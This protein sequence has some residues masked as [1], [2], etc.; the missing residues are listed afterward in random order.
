MIL[1]F[2][3]Q[4]VCLSTEKSKTADGKLFKMDFL[5][6]AP[7]RYGNYAQTLARI[8]ARMLARILP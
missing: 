7:L 4:E 5:T 2:W 8:L 6:L 1:C 3:L